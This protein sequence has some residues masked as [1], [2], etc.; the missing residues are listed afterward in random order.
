MLNNEAEYD[1][2]LAGLKDARNLKVDRIS[3]FWDSLLIVSE[4]NEEYAAKGEKMAIYLRL[5]KEWEAQFSPFKIIQIPKMKNE[6]VDHLA[7]ITSGIDKDP[8]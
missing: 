5:V 6:E 8:L 1:A 7:R 3:M 4:I 2:L